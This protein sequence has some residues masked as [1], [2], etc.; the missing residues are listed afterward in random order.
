MKKQN[1]LLIATVLLAFGLL[2]AAFVLFEV[3][4]DRTGR[5]LIGKPVASSISTFLAPED[6]TGVSF[7]FLSDMYIDE[8]NERHSEFS[9]L[10]FMLQKEGAKAR[11]LH[12]GSHGAPSKSYDDAVNAKRAPTHVIIADKSIAY[13]DSTIRRIAKPCLLELKDGEV[14]AIRIGPDFEEWIEQK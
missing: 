4:A 1:G 2:G 10:V 5:A 11:M 13:A 9:D 12:I 3:M 6:M 8:C 14:V 7:V